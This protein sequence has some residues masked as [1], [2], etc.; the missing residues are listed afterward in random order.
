VKNL[1]TR[2][3]CAGIVA[4]SL[5]Y[6]AETD[7]TIGP[8]YA[9]SPETKAKD[10]VPK[11]ELREFTMKSEDSR[12][13]E[14]TRTSSRSPSPSRSGSGCKSASATTATTATT[15]PSTTGSGPTA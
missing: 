2:F 14:S 3:A 7:F 8:D 5:A 12:I 11:G 13:Y 1:L 9:D 6:A 10:G 15:R 4:L